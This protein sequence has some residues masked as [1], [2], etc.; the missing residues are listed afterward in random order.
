[1]LPHTECFFAALAGR[2]MASPGSF[3]ALAGRFSIAAVQ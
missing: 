3:F 1:M 2:I